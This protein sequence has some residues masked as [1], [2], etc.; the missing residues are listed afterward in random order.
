MPI[1]PLKYQITTATRQVNH[2][3]SLLEQQ[4]LENPDNQEAISLLEDIQVFAGLL[5]EKAET[6]LKKA[7]AHHRSPE[8]CHEQDLTAVMEKW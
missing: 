5:I 7:G 2:L 6:T 3:F 8:Q 1:T 4:L